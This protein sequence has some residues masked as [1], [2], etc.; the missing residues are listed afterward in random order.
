MADISTGSSASVVAARPELSIHDGTVTTTSLQVAQFFGKRHRDV[1]RA[2]RSLTAEIPEDHARNFARM[3]HVVE[4]GS[5]ASR[6]E[7][8]YRMTREGFMLLAMGFTGKE[9]L[10]WKLA[11]IAAFNRMEAELQKPA[12]DPQRIQLAQR[13][14]TQAAAQV[15]QAVF[16]AVMAA[17]NTDWRHARY[18]LNLG[19]DREGQPIVPHAQPIGDDQMIVS[20]NAL[21]ERIASGEILSATDAQLAT[22][23]TACTQ[24]LT[25][26][27]QHREKQAAKPSLPAAQDASS[28][29]PG[30]LMMTFK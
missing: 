29:P 3:V 7:S 6:E 18:L 27:A 26:R 19:Y 12:Q 20:F 30:T 16:D 14:A 10:R 25:Q 8:A 15:T 21:P 11:Y 24:R 28:L 17:D 1:M 9:A 13:L 2:I 5:G 23:A 22:L 4:I